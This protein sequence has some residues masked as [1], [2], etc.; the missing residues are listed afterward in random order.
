MNAPFALVEARAPGKI[1]L[2]GEH[3]V[4][5]GRPALAVP[6]FGVRAR[7]LVTRTT[8]PS[9][10]FAPAVGVDAPLASLEP[11]H[12][13][14]RTVHLAETVLGPLPPVVIRI[15]SDIPVAAGLGSGAAVAV[16][17]LRSLA[18]F[19]GQALPPEELN[20]LAYEIEKLHHGTPSGI[21]NTVITYA[22]PILYRRGAGWQPLQVRRSVPLVIA[23]SGRKAST[24]QMVA[25]VR[26]RREAAPRRY[27]ALFDAIAQTVGVVQASLASGDFLRLGRA[28]RRN[29]DL[30]AE[31]GVSTPELDALVAAACAAG[32]YGA[33]LAG[34]G[35]G[36]NVVAVTPPDHQE[37][38]AR[39]LRAAGATRVITTWVPS[40]EDV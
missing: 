23:D 5:Y 8:G 10:I 26:A 15:L 18:G 37:R 39:A 2:A 4:V 16:A 19:V 25:G 28:L 36:G 31:M 7:A 3:A 38:V 29:H 1:I 30:L 11:E 14:R 33:K 12:P 17:V 21:D 6:V 22:R 32:A 35:G 13:L 20:A 40:T 34:A 27:D 24:R 9:W